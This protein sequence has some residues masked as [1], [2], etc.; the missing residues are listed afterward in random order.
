MILE[1]IFG[2]TKNNYN[3]KLRRKKQIIIDILLYLIQ[4]FLQEIFR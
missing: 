1:E 4:Y 3:R 2:G